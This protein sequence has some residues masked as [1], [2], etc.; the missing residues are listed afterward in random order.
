MRLSRRTAEAGQLTPQSSAMVAT[1]SRA[2]AMSLL[3]RCAPI[4]EWVKMPRLEVAPAW[5][6]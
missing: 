2:L 4:W 1:G 6:L 5:R 3:T